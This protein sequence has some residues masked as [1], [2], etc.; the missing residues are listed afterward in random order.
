VI[1]RTQRCEHIDM[2]G[3]EWWSGRNSHVIYSNLHINDSMAHHN[4][5]SDD[6]IDI[7]HD[8]MMTYH[9]MAWWHITWWHDDI[10]HDD[11]SHD[12]IS[13]DDMM[14]YHMMTWWHITW[15]HDDISHDDIS[16]I[17]ISH[18][19]MMTYH[20]MTYHMMTS[21]ILWNTWLMVR[22]YQI[23]PYL[24]PCTLHMYVM[25]PCEPLICSWDEEF[26]Q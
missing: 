15:W 10:S 2:M 26:V 24:I 16:H 3:C 7:S 13:H 19:G 23:R 21:L 9:M 25:T 14:T 22:M 8:D 1:W 18:D 17:D 11:I 4:M 6:V 20:M 12:D 5:T